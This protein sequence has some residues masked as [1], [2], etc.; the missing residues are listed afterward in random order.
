M[1]IMHGDRGIPLS[2]IRP[3]GMDVISNVALNMYGSS[4]QIIS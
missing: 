4:H 1:G 3:Y 2:I